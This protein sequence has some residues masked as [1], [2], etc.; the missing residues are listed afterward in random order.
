MPEAFSQRIYDLLFDEDEERACSDISETEC[1]VAPKNFALNAGNGAATKLAEQLASP[2][3]TLTWMLSALGAPVFISGL[4]VPVR[5]AGSLLPQLAASGAIRAAALRKRV[6]VWAAIAQSVSMAIIAIAAGSL[7]GLGLGVVVTVT[8]A[9]FSVASGV[10]SV[11]YKDVLA[12]T[13]PKGRRGRLLA[14]RA[15]IGGAL[16]LAAG[17][18]LFLTFEGTET[19]LPYV[20]LVASAAALF[21]LSAILFGMI[22]EE[23]GATEGGRTP[24]QELKK[25]WQIFERDAPFRRFVAARALLLFVLLL[26]PFY[27]IVSKETT[28]ESIGALG[29]FVIA[30]GVGRLLGGPLWGKLA[31]SAADRAMVLGGAL[32]LL[33][34][35]YTF[36]FPFFADS[37]GSFWWLAPVFVLNAIAYAGIR[38]G[39]KTYLVDYT[40]ADERPLYVS[41]ANTLVGIV[42]LA[43]SLL[44]LIA[45]LTSVQVTIAVGIVLLAGG[46]GFAL[47]LPRVSQSS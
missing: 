32:A 46:V 10:E 34:A 43:G 16:T 40:P 4:L 26:Q 2:D 41:L 19:R 14:T 12:K 28:G 24:F 36:A 9:L 7:S 45:Q 27:I 29:M 20:L 31:D 44:G 3:I 8:L 42:M 13:I 6:W 47:G 11:A 35:G 22:D 1:K 25:G 33:V 17:L 38:L 18:L 15:T 23:P 30:A 5:R 39:R 21:A 37:A